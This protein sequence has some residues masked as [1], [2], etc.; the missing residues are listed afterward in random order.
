MSL[1]QCQHCGCCE[2]TALSW[3]GFA[4]FIATS[5][6]WTGIEDREGK[7]LCSACGPS[8][9]M[10]GESTDGGKWHNKFPRVF[11]P[12]GMFRTAQNGN[13]EHVETGEQAYR[14]YAVV[15]RAQEKDAP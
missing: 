11:L 12:L 1:F 10:N 5:C 6:D 14:K 9:F 8:R 13:L 2:N 4:V 7:K 15:H 3:Q